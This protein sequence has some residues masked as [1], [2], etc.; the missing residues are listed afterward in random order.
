MAERGRSPG[1]RMSN[2]HR[3]KIKNSNI[4]NALIEHATGEREMSA[5]Q[6]T[7]GLGLLKKVMPDMQ[8]VALSGDE[9]GA[10]IVIRATIGG[11]AP[12]NG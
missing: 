2:E 4:L 3:D 1:F 11:D 6:V 12:N 9:E 5:T 8:A 10:P 7:A